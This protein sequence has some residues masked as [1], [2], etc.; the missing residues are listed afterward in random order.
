MGSDPVSPSSSGPFV[1]I[2]KSCLSWPKLLS[3]EFPVIASSESGCGVEGLGFGRGALAASPPSG[4]LGPPRARSNRPPPPAPP[5]PPRPRWPPFC[6][7]RCGGPGI[8][9]PRAGPSG[10]RRLAAPWA[11]ASFTAT[12][13]RRPSAPLATLTLA[14]RRAHLAPLLALASA[15]AAATTTTTPAAAGTAGSLRAGRH[16]GE[17]DALSLAVD[18]QNPDGHDVAHA[19][20]V[21]RAAD[22]AVGELADV[23]EAGVLEADIDEGAEVDHVQDGALELHALGQVFELEHALLEDRLGQVF[24]R[25]AVG[26]GQGFA[27]V[28]QGRL[29]DTEVAGRRRDIDGPAASLE[30]PRAW[31][32]SRIGSGLVAQAFEELGGGLVAFRVDPGAV[33][34]VA[35]IAD[36]QEAGGLGE[37]DRAD[38]FDL[39]DL[40]AAVKGPFSSRWS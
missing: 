11:R 16:H 24:T 7:A 33:E 15:A 36:L 30:W 35:L 12:A 1:R 4:G 2:S 38:A 21:V 29:A 10:W 20:D 6:I 31:P 25:V 34:R 17:R 22:V 5:G 19:D 3:G 13:T 37:G 40:V 18:A 28:E 32:R 27:D 14:T 23:D 8:R 9:K 39:A 26:P